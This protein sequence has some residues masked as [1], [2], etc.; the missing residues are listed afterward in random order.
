MGGT[1][2]RVEPPKYDNLITEFYFNDNSTL[3]QGLELDS[4]TGAITGVPTEVFDLFVFTVM[5]A[6]PS[7]VTATTLTLSVRLGS[8][9]AEAGFP[10]TVVG[11]RA[12]SACS[13]YGSFVGTQSRLCTLGEKDGEWGKTTGFCTAVSLLVVLVI[14][15]VI[16]VVVIC[17]CIIRR[18]KKTKVT[19]GVKGKKSIPSKADKESQM[20]E[21]KI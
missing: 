4:T 20:K 16:V 6:N 3:P 18:M 7:G 10:T 1:V 13:Y 9:Q 14:V 19:G 2:V 17:V 11:E 8:C 12:T 15:A 21:V 5:G